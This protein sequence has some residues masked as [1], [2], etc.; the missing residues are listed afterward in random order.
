VDL[1]E[2]GARRE[3]GEVGEAKLKP[4]SGKKSAFST[5]RCSFN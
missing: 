5:K 3:L 1:G 2:R 4:S